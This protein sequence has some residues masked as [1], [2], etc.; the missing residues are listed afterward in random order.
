MPKQNCL[1]TD[2]Y[3]THTACTHTNIQTYTFFRFFL[4]AMFGSL[5]LVTLLWIKQRKMY[6]FNTCVNC[7]YIYI[8]IHTYVCLHFISILS[9]LQT[10]FNIFF[11][12][13]CLDFIW[14]RLEGI[15]IFWGGLYM[16]C[17]REWCKRHLPIMNQLIKVLNSSLIHAC[18][19]KE[20][21]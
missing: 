12:C 7:I 8:Y 13:G 11:L 14:G 21:E 16:H 1:V 2:R 15:I 3:E 6:A 18:N 4:P 19:T 9:F 17:N 5:T 20:H 10:I